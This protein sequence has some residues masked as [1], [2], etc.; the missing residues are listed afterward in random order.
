MLR[1]K[2]SNMMK[3]LLIDLVVEYN[4][5]RKLEAIARDEK[6]E[7]DARA[8]YYA[9]NAL[10]VIIGKLLNKENISVTRLTETFEYFN[11]VDFENKRITAVQIYLPVDYVNS[12]Y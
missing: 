7:T 4:H 12:Q 3:D 5:E 1:L 9:A 6:N 11:K 2:G 10:T 8:H